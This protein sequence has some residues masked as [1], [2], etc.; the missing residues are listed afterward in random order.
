MPQGLPLRGE[1][2]YHQA[3]RQA[4]AVPP[5]RPAGVASVLAKLARGTAPAGLSFCPTCGGSRTVPLLPCVGAFT[6]YNVE[7]HG[8]MGTFWAGRR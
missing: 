6:R 5:A 2:A 1:A 4:W 8:T 7:F 3:A